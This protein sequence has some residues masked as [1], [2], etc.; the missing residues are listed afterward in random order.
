MNQEIE[1]N[2]SFWIDVSE[3]KSRHGQEFSLLRV[4]QTGSGVHPTFYPI[5]T[6]GLFPRGLSGRDVKLTTHLQLVPRSRKY[7]SIH[8]LPYTPS[9]RCVFLVKH[10]DKFTITFTVFLLNIKNRR[11]GIVAQFVLD[12]YVVAQIFET[13][14]YLWKPNVHYHSHKR[15]SP[16]TTL[17][18]TNPVD[19]LIVYRQ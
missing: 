15:P 19:I 6:G 3:F 10:R 7:G 16:E 5:G 14:L 11:T 9:W 8:P 4:V 17:T 13:F 1:I 12:K 2:A 18:Q